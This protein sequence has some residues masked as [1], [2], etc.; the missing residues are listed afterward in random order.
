MV[1]IAINVAF[2]I[3]AVIIMVIITFTVIKVIA[4]YFNSV[5]KTKLRVLPPVDNFHLLL[6]LLN[7]I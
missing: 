1:P 7:T 2:V 3:I 6:A 5:I 4:Q